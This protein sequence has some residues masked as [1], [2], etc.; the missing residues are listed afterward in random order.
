MSRQVWIRSAEPVVQTLQVRVQWFLSIH[1]ALQRR[2]LS[3]RR[4]LRDY[5]FRDSCKYVLNL[6]QV[7]LGLAVSHSSTTFL[8]YHLA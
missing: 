4:I 8:S 5:D 6:T 7:R 3:V 2:D 1:L